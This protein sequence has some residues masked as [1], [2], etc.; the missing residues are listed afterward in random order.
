MVD[1]NWRALPVLTFCLALLFWLAIP[2]RASTA[3]LVE[4]ELV[5]RWPH[6]SGAFTQGLLWDGDTLLE[7]SGLY[8]RSWLGRW[9]PDDTAPPQR[10]RLSRRYFAEGLTRLDD[11]L[12]LLTWREGR[13]LVFDA[14]TLEQIDSHRYRGEGWGLTD[15]GE[16]LIMSDG[17]A[18]LRFVDP[19]NFSELARLQITDG[20]NPVTQLNELEWIPAAAPLAPGAPRILANRW[21]TEEIV[22]IDPASGNVTGRLD[23]RDLYPVRERRPGDDVLNG[24]AYDPRDATLWVTGKHWPWL[25]QLRL[26]APL[27]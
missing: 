18:T 14:Q 13:A 17:S 27:P 24:I 5:K 20:G 9:R 21:Q 11:R 12:Y 8:G 4:W 23:L 2:A 25:Y 1:R 16:R 10:V 6:R 15:D 19:E 3:T 22:V 26:P 7:S